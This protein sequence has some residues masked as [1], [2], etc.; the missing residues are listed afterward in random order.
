MPVQQPFRCMLLVHS[1][2]PAFFAALS[3]NLDV[4]QVLY[5]PGVTSLFVSTLVLTTMLYFSDHLPRYKY[6]KAMLRVKKGRLLETQAEL[7]ELPV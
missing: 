6:S 3:L 1:S 7:A 4:A 5:L 2:H